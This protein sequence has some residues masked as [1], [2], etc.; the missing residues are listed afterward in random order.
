LLT[1]QS[2]FEHELKKLIQEAVEA[3]KENLAFGS[4]TVDFA[5]YRNQVGVVA[6]LR[7]ALELCDEANR[8]CEQKE[9][10]G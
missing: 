10:T 5:A 6:G 7:L 8:V 3:R 1:Y 9:R 2:F 4:G